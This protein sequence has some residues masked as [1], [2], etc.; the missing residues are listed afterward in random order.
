M[1]SGADEWFNNNNGSAFR[2]FYI[3]LSGGAEPC[4]HAI[5]SDMWDSFHKGPLANGQRWYCKMCTARY[6]QKWGVL[7]E[8][9]LRGSLY[10]CM[11]DVPDCGIEDAKRMIID[12]NASSPEAL[13]E[14]LPKVD[15]FP[16]GVVFMEQV[17]RPGREGY[18]K[19]NAALFRSIGRF[20]WAQ[21]YNLSR[22]VRARGSR[23]RRR[24]GRLLWGPFTARDRPIEER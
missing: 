20:D 21:L 18:Y 6:R 11:A 23:R 17:L 15:S 12:R 8:V 22:P 2:T 5:L 16:A 9:K 1:S 7:C 13:L 14:M 10:Y 19:F 3:C 24:S 4:G